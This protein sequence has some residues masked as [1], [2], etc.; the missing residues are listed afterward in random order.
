MRRVMDGILPLKF[1]GAVPNLILSSF[2][3]GLLAL[4]GERSG[5]SDLGRPGVIECK[6]NHLRADIIPDMS[7]E[8]Q[9]GRRWRFGKL[10]LALW[11]QHTGLKTTKLLPTMATRKWET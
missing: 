2:D 9:G 3:H 11:L 10:H 7:L 1:N 8:K 4:S 6:C 5:E